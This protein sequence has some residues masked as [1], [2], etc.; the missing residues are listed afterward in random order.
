MPRRRRTRP[1]RNRNASKA[2]E[3]MRAAK[4]ARRRRRGRS[5]V[6]PMSLAE[7]CI[8]DDGA[9]RTAIPRSTRVLR[10]HRSH[11]VNLRLVRELHPPL[12]GAFRILLANGSKFPSGRSYRLPDPA[13]V[14]PDGESLA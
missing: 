10:V 11:A 5:C 4:A 14:R 13:F 8:A 9:A 2:N 3:S 7:R 1:W 6:W 12:H